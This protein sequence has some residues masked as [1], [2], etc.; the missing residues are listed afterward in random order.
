MRRTVLATL[1]T[2]LCCMLPGCG[3][4]KTEGCADCSSSESGTAI[5]KPIPTRTIIA[6]FSARQETDGNV[7]FFRNTGEQISAEEMRNVINSMPKDETKGIEINVLQPTGDA[8]RLWVPIPWTCYG[9]VLNWEKHFLGGCIKRDV[10]HLG[11][12]VQNRCQGRMIFDSHAAAW[13]E[14]G[15]QFGLYVTPSIFCRTTRGGYTAV[16]D[17]IR[18]ALLAAGLG[19]S[20]ALIISEFSTP[21]IIPLLGL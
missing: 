13:W 15:P 8:S 21:V 5:S 10:W 20:A 14:N 12:Q 1:L 9:I 11:F 18:N 19:A 16:R 4:N 2:M 17:T 3:G 7:R 6:S